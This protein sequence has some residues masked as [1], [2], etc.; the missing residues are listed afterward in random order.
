MRQPLTYLWTYHALIY[1]MLTQSLDD[2]YLLLRCETNDSSLN[3]TANRSLVN[4]NEAV[5]S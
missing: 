5:I 2:L 3:D 4:R 1:Q